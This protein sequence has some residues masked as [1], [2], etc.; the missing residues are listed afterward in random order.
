[1]NVH[2]RDTEIVA[3]YDDGNAAIIKK[4]I[5]LGATIISGLNLGKINSLG[6]SVGDDLRREAT[7]GTDCQA[8]NII[9]DFAADANI[10][11]PVIAG[12][13][14]RAKLLVSEN[15]AV[16]IIFEFRNQKT[17]A[18]IS[19]PGKNFKCWRNILRNESGTVDVNSLKLDFNRHEA[20]VLILS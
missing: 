7:A 9:L 12:D 20:K 11:I 5:G 15:I 3:V 2:G 18:C 4:R 14:F 6:T 13:G 10:S 1:W 8:A 16:L 17:T 19:F